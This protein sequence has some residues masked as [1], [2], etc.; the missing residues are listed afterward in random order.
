V[1]RRSRDRP[2]SSG[3]ALPPDDPTTD[4]F[5]TLVTALVEMQSQG[6]VRPDEPQREALFVWSVVHGVA[7]LAL[8]AILQTPRAI[9]ALGGCANER[10]WT[11]IV[12][13]SAL[14]AEP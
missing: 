2:K 8:D 4:A 3:T 11:G 12:N 5:G 1:R 13:P 9:E 6:L 14:S 10:L 7:M